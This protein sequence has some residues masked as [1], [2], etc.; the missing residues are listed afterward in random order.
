MEFLHN[1]W[2]ADE[3]VC[4][5]IIY[6]LWTQ[7]SMY[8]MKKIDHT[9]LKDYKEKISKNIFISCFI[10]YCWLYT[11]LI[12]H[13]IASKC[14]WNAKHLFN[15]TTVSKK[16]IFVYTIYMQITFHTVQCNRAPKSIFNSSPPSAAYMHQWIGWALFRTM[17]CCLFGA[18]PLSKPMLRYCQLDP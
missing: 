1:L 7:N 14:V 10:K 8:E 5:G 16:Y 6:G 12:F 18:K 9:I 17:A 15:S 3:L 11:R 13:F 2:L 4:I